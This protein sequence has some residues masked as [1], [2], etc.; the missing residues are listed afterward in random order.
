ML[1]KIQKILII[2]IV[3]LTAV[4]ICDVCRQAGYTEILPEM[5][6]RMS[7]TQS[8]ESESETEHREEKLPACYDVRKTGKAP[9]L[10]NQ[11][12]LGT[13]W[14]VAASS[15]LESR[16]LP[17]ESVVFSADHISTLNSYATG[18]DKGGAYMISTAYLTAWQ[19]P[20]TEEMDPYGD[21]ETPEGL[22][23]VRHVQ[24]V[25]M[26]TDRDFMTIKNLIYTYGAV[27]SSMYMDLGGERTR[28]PFYN[29]E[30]ASYYYDGEEQINHDIVILG[31]D[32]DYP[33]E[34]FT[35]MPS[36][37]GAFICQ[38]SWGEGFGE[39]GIFYVSYDDT[40]IG[41]NCVAYTRVEP[42]D[43]YAHIYQ[44]D[45]CGWVGQMG[46]G[47]EECWFA[48]VYTADS[49]QILRAVGFYA[50]GK[51]TKYEIYVVKD[52]QNTLS[53]VLPEKVQRGS[54][55]NVGFYTIDLEK[56]YS[57]PAGGSFAV[58]VKVKVP[59]SEHP[60]AMEYRSDETTANVILQDG[61]GYVSPDG[62]RWTSMEE[63][64]DGNI[65]LKAY[66]DDE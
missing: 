18:Q 11:G 23:P 6:H 5:L 25:Q 28:S 29:R 54:L 37:N 64:Y 52:F 50:T 7:E 60:A 12:T 63:E 38:N 2:V 66:T 32:D 58:M 19:G 20:V 40:C 13:C 55:R 48:N 57:I 42:T 56:T 8:E 9:T 51:H 61:Q 16:L 41:S 44:S 49:P 27:Q 34:N 35:R 14:A 36:R 39:D 53:L 62:Y 22:L 21:G 59:G 46:Y 15:V 4:L 65:C 17:Q 33:A 47:A 30:H 10:K 3:C 24:E 43:N 1:R 26:V 45:L 31:W